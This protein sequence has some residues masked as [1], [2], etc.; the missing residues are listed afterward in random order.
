MKISARP[1]VLPA[2]LAFAGAS[3]AQG[4]FPTRPVTP[5]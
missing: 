5:E 1:G 2:G 4:P 3:P